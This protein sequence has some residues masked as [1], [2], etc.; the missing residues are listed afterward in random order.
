MRNRFLLAAA[1]LALPSLA[2]AQTINF[3]TYVSVGDS[4]A[5]GFVSGSLVQTHQATSVPALLARQAAV[6]DF[7]QPL[8]S[9]PGI[10]S[11]L[12]LVSLVPTPTL[13]RITGQGRPLNLALPRPY[14]N[15]AVPGATLI[16]S[17]QRVSDGGG[18]H[19]LI[20]RGQ[21]TQIQQAVALRPTFVTLWIGNNDVLGAA[22][23]GRAIDGVTL[24]PTP[25]F[26]AAYA[27]A[28]ATLKATGATVIAANL[29]DVTSIAFV[30]TV[31]P[32]V[33][34]P[35][36]QSPVVVNG[37]TVPLFGPAGP[38]P[39]SSKV[40][41]GASALLA[42]GIGI[43]A[44][45]GGRAAIV[46]GVCQN[47]LPDEVVLDASE[48]SIIT[49]HVDANNAAIREICAAANVPVVDINGFLRSTS[50]G[51]S[52][53]GI[54]LST[55]FLTG[56]LVSYDGVHPTDIGYALVANEW[57]RV[58]NENG[59]HL[60]PVDLQPFLKVAAGGPAVAA[61]GAREP[62]AVLSLEAYASLREIF[63][64]VNQR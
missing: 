31:P 44:A 20:L 5:A 43:P 2:G 21:G 38:L 15:L 63:G 41:L 22:V 57:I 46:N 62:G 58:I 36:T 24:T 59:G 56:G 16:D 64:P 35:A 25:A 28:V 39:S 29:P 11:E 17:L 14:N 23:G 37:Q 18:L 1:V 7:Q 40:T 45:I 53:G 33:V 8:V 3:G 32:V 34:N 30:N 6:A 26:R 51:I 10:P 54:N 12:Q 50:A 9:T 27:A 47:C 49:A 55:S 42:Q 4:L 61:A 19:D 60:E 48:L 13:V 52:V